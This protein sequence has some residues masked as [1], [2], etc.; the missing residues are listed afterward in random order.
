[1]LSVAILLLAIAPNE[2]EQARDRQDRAALERLAT[3][4][5]SAAAKQPA[6]AQA[7][8]LYAVAQS[9]LAEVLTELKDKN[10]G[11]AAA[12]TGIKAA[13]KAVALKPGVAENHR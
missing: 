4:Y 6:D 8:Y 2:L 1:M 13:E 10:G 12:E 9:Y 11:R 5:G 3:S 7:Q